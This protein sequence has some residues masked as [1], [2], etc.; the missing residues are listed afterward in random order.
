MTNFRT[1][2][3]WKLAMKDFGLAEMS[4]GQLLLLFVSLKQ[5]YIIFWGGGS[6][7]SDIEASN[8]TH[9]CILFFFSIMWIDFQLSFPKDNFLSPICFLI[10]N[11]S[12]N[13]W[14]FDGGIQTS[15]ISVRCEC[16]TAVPSQLNSLFS[17]KVLII[18][19]YTDMF[20]KVMAEIEKNTCIKAPYL[21]PSS[22]K[23]KN[24][25]YFF[26]GR[27]GYDVYWPI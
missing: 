11:I 6:V 14:V 9:F 19:Q 1:E 16:L 18:E 23:P 25:I 8:Q 5:I 10:L 3:L 7:N 26:T 13:V 4:H 27:S 2:M 15:E 22:S 20:K 12:F 17:I 24:Y 21:S